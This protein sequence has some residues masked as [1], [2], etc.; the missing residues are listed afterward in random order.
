MLA[1]AP[2][3]RPSWREDEEVGSPGQGIHP[4]KRIQDN[5]ILYQGHLSYI[6]K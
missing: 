2:W 4:L 1:M 3:T 6:G 5:Y